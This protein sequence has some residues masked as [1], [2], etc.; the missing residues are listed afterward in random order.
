[1]T[2]LK[3]FNNF[4]MNEEFKLPIPRTDQQFLVKSIVKNINKHFN[5]VFNNNDIIITTNNKFNNTTDN[6]NHK[7]LD[8]HKLKNTVD[9]LITLEKKL[10]E[11]GV[12]SEQTPNLKID[13][14]Q[15]MLTF[16]VLV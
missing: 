1:M 3:K 12:L 5:V 10:Y 15:I 4:K 14:F 11:S 8:I 13:N 2:K 7:V 9:E 6:N 16:S